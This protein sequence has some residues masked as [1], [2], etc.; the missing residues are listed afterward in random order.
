MEQ[1][2]EE[3]RAAGLT[4]VEK[5]E[6]AGCGSNSGLS[7]FYVLDNVPAHSV[8]LMETREKATGYPRG[9]ITLGFC[10]NCGFIPN[11]SYDPA[12]HE[13]SPLCE[14]TQGFS[15]TFNAFARS[16]AERLV[17]KYSLRGKEIIEI[18]CGKGEFL[19]MLC[20]MG[21]NRGVGFDPA[22]AKGRVKAAQ[23]RDVRFINDFYS[24]KY[25]SCKG[26]FI[27]CRMTLEHVQNVADMLVNIRRSI[28]DRRDTAVFFQVP[29]V[30]RV[31]NGLAFW[32]IYYEHC[33]Y[34]S[35]GSL[36]RILRLCGFEVV[37]LR[38]DFDGQY[39]LCEASP[40]RY[41]GSATVLD[42][43][44]VS[45]LFCALKYFTENHAQKTAIWKHKLKAFLRT[46]YRCVLWG[47]G[48]KGAAFL[49]TLG[50][51]DEVRYVVDINPRRHSTF[52]P[53]TGHEIVSPE[54]L[55][56]YRP[57]VVVV[58]NP[59]YTAEITDELRSMGLCPRVIAV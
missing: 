36:S 32:D 31:L 58:M 14:E 33:S 40:A 48:S 19:T 24:E 11:T 45:A 16:L 25:A 41:S 43:Q 17:E 46:G 10:N 34:F 27:V 47:S 44:D 56:S 2:F 29:D 35:P 37:D 55:R 42:G 18:G 23:A 39:I 38:T 20:E 7:I 49:T 57:D 15:G 3:M 13:Y 30:T 28:G 9:R 26:D 12:L 21:G 4:R 1:R 22:Y 50:V 54:F 59:A 52:M 5:M 6:C 51:A 53:G 8:L